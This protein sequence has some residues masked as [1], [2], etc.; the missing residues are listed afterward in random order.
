RYRGHWGIRLDLSAGRLR[1]SV[2]ASDEVPIRVVLPGR[3]FTV[4]PGDSCAL[5][6]PGS[7]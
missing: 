3:E 5:D 7:G 1:I 6:L 2:P 4:A